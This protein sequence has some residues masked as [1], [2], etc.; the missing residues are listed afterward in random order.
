MPPK[1][2]KTRPRRPKTAPRGAQ[3]GPRRPQDAGKRGS[4]SDPKQNPFQTSILERFGVDFRPILGGF[5]SVFGWILEGSGVDYGG[6]LG[7]FFCYLCVSISRHKEAQGGTISRFFG[8]LRRLERGH[9]GSKTTQDG[10]KTGQDGVAS[11]ARER[12]QRAKRAKR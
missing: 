1:R 5:G 11:A 8:N 3:N 12:A 10:G 2:P 9:D 7:S 4:E 6:W